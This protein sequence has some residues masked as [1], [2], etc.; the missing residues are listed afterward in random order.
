VL[1]TQGSIETRPLERDEELEHLD[2]ALLSA[3]AGAGRL[4]VVHGPS[5][6]GKSRLLAEA[7]ARAGARGH[8]VAC[9]RGS[10]LERGFPFGLVLRL[11]EGLLR[12]GDRPSAAGVLAGHAAPAAP[13]LMP[14]DDDRAGLDTSDEFALIHG[15]Y[16]CVV[17]LSERHP[18]ALIVDDAHWGDELSLRFLNYLAA[19]LADLPV[20]VVVGIRTGDPDPSSDLVARLLD[21]P[22]SISLRPRELSEAAT[23]VLL[24]QSDVAGIGKPFVRRAW[25]ATRGNPFLITELVCAMR[26]EPDA[27]RDPAPSRLED[28]APEAV[29]RTIARRLARL[30]ADA[31][32]LATACAVLG[33]HASLGRVLAL[34]R[35]D[36]GGATAAAAR[37]VDAGILAGSDPPTFTHPMF[38]AAIH[39]QLDGAAR[40][41][42]HLRAARVLH[43]DGADID[44]VARH[45]IEGR[46]TDEP[47][48][49]AALH[50]AARRMARRGA[51][52][53]AVRYLRRV[54][55]AVPAEQLSGSL[56]IDLGTVE[57]AAGELTS[58]ARFERALMLIDEPAERA[59]ALYSLGLTQYRRGL[60]ADALETMKRGVA[61]FADIDPDLALTFRGGL[62]CMQVIIARNELEEARQAASAL[63]G[64]APRTTAERV[65]LAPL[66]LTEA[67]SHPHTADAVRLALA[68]LGDGALVAEQTCEGMAAKIAIYA[69]LFSGRA[70]DAQRAAETVMS[71]ARERGAV[72]AYAEA[73]LARAF[74]L[75]ERGL[76]VEAMADAHVA[77][78]HVDRGWELY[79]GTPRS[80]LIRCLIETGQ[81]E[82]AQR[83]LDAAAPASD[84]PPGLDL[85]WW[86]AS[87]LV[88]M[89]RFAYA[90]ALRDFRRAGE[91]LAQ[92]DILNPSVFPYRMYAALA[93][94]GARDRRLARA[95]IDEQI[96]LADTFALPATL[97]AALRVRA[98]LEGAPDDIETLGEAVDLL[99]GEDAQLELAHALHDLGAVLRRAGSRVA[100]REPLRRA[101]AIAH[102]CGAAPLE[103]SALEELLATGARPRRVALTGAEALTPS[104]RR[105]ARLALGDDTPRQI[106]ER[107]VLSK[108][109]VVWHLTRI[110]RKLNVK[111]RAELR[112]TFVADELGDDLSNPPDLTT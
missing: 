13:L 85:S 50:R 24:G 5:G 94:H 28:F 111:S 83:Q 55:G 75:F 101:A 54:A 4:V 68:A 30:G 45:L 84:G 59:R 32:E 47:W 99:E 92:A 80:L 8:A 48:A 112:A 7:E 20:A 19:R 97:A 79:R 52:G 71:D 38:V 3:R 98:H 6:I 11:F 76:V 10:E 65:I 105:I 31:S 73:S 63:R 17:N 70:L 56:L 81:R 18:L 49:V 91:L 2:R 64:R 103:A 82:E 72:V 16:W 9:A 36:L 60:F 87:G 42:A 46:P 89:T 62:Y 1:S 69:L 110:Y 107:L 21:E 88:A 58:P 67:L 86:M 109:T 22:G 33:D 29:G 43:E 40:A 25:E 78:D 35:L 102:R 27:W 61:L 39:A 34:A 95:L 108:S 51:P 93:A 37:L 41:S 44:V 96:A 104:E 26:E 57:A 74:A 23:A 12:R 106:A 77:V 15:L 14:A 53:V 66:A 90:D 100:A